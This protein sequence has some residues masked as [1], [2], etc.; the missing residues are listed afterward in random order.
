MMKS[1][2]DT[3][4]RIR[5]LASDQKQEEPEKITSNDTSTTGLVKDGTISSLNED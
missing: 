3:H 2:H 5:I 4:G 1:K